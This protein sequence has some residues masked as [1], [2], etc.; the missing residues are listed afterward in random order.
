MNILEINLKNPIN[1]NVI[2]ELKAKLVDSSK[3]DLLIIDTG[4]HDFT[5]IDVIKYFRQQMESL[6]TELLTFKK[7][8][9]IHP[10]QY[11][12][13]SCNPKKY[14]YFTSKTNAKKWL[15]KLEVV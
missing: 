3:F 4:K 15:F 7:T 1:H 14:N 5:S 13:K 12:N 11:K 8:A 9:L 2:N 6:E 10:P